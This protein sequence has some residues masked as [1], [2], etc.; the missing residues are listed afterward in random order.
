MDIMF[1]SLAATGILAVVGVFVAM[2][3]MCAVAITNMFDYTDPEHN[4]KKEATKVDSTED[5]K[6][7]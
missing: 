5:K 2:F 3:L 1:I 6:A 7:A 4:I